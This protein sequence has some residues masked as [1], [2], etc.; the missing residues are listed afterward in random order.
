M[1]LTG[2]LLALA[3]AVLLAPASAQAQADNPETICTNLRSNYPTEYGNLF[4][5]SL[6][7]EQQLEACVAT[8]TIERAQFTTQGPAAWFRV[9][10][11]DG[12][13]AND[14]AFRY[15]AASIIYNQKRHD[16]PPGPRP[17]PED[18]FIMESSSPAVAVYESR[19]FDSG[20][21]ECSLWHVNLL[22]VPTPTCAGHDFELTPERP[23]S[24]HTPPPPPPPPGHHPPPAQRPILSATVGHSAL[25]YRAFTVFQRLVVNNVPAKA[26]VRVTCTKRG[27]KA[28]TYKTTK[29]KRRLNLIKPFR[30][31]RLKVGTKVRITIT[32]P[33][34]IGKRITYT[35]RRRKLPF[36]KLAL[37]P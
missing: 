29:A 14:V 23:P 18:R 26:R 21:R 9:G 4:Q 32:A 24:P 36:S 33:G 8:V 13:L 11:N 17:R 7:P 12:N 27:C 31:R 34:F 15:T 10:A 6:P 35:I 5:S 19:R 1:Q 16:P 2:S 28:K 22:P 25:A 30:K 3:L 37:R 20:F